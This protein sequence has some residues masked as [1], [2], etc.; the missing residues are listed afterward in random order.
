M[1]QQREFDRDV[2][3]DE[4]FLGNE[5]GEVLDGDVLE[6]LDGGGALSC[7]EAGRRAVSAHARRHHAAAPHPLPPLLWQRMRA[8]G[9]GAPLS[10]HLR[11]RG[12]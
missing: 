9:G 8:G 4:G 11:R 2:Y 7:V 3:D 10:R 1:E 12:L 6:D 5:E